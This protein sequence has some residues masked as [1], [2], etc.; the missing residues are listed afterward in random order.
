MSKLLRLIAGR[1]V[2]SSVGL[3][4]VAA[5]IWILGPQLAFGTA[6]PLESSTG[7]LI[8]IL[9]V[10]LI[11]VV[12]QLRKVLKANQANKG[13]VEGLVDAKTM[14]PDRSAEEVATL[15]DRFEKAVGVLRKSK[16]K[17]GS[18][19]LYDL[20]WYII[21]GPPGSGKTTALVNSGLEFPLA[22][23][24]GREALGGVG[25][26]RNCDW[27]FTDEAILLDT[28]GRYT[29]QDSDAKIDRSA[30]EGFLGLLRKYR[31]RR[32]INGVVVA[33][34]LLDLM[35]L[36]EHERVAHARAIKAR[37]QEL[38]QF[39]KI[40][41][42]V[43]V[44]LTKTDLVAGFAEFFEDLG[45]NE[46]EQV[47]GMTFPIDAS[48]SPTGAAER[49]LPEFDALLARLNARL[50]AR[51]S[52]E[53][54]P[55]RRAAI[56]G[57]PRQLASL[58]DNIGSFLG[59]VF[60]GS[61]FEQA[62]ML[63][64]VYFTSGTQEGTPI[65][66]LM[67]MV[68]RTFGLEQHMLPA[69][70][71]RGRSY[72]LKGLLKDVVFRESEVAGTNRKF[73]LQRVWLQRAAYVG[74]LSLAVLVSIGWGVSYLN[75]RAM[76]REVGTA[77]TAAAQALDQVQGAQDVLGL[78]PA[79][80][81]V[82]AIPAIYEGRDDA[83]WLQGLG[84]Y[85]GRKLSARSEAAYQRVLR[86]SLLPLLISRTEGHLRNGGAT[87][88]FQYEALK[89]YLMLDSRE[90]YDARAVIGWFEF[91]F[92]QFLSPRA[93]EPERTAFLAHL[94]ALF[95]EQPLPLPVALD[96]ALI[97][98][99]QRI[100]ARMA[101]E[102]RVYSRLRQS[103]AA[104]QLPDFT[105]FDAAGPRSQIVFTRRSGSGPGD[106]IDGFFTRDGYRQFFVSQSGAEASVL[107]DESWILGPYVPTNLD[108]DTVMARVKDLYLADYVQQYEALLADIALA[109]SSSAEETSDILNILS[110]P[111]NSPL[112]LLLRAVAEQTQLEPPAPTSQDAGA[113]A[114]ARGAVQRLEGLLGGGN[115]A[116][117]AAA[118]STTNLVDERF[119]WLRDL[120]GG[121]DAAAAPIQPVL[122]LI[123]ELY[124]FMA[125]VVAQRGLQGDIPT[126]LADQGRLVAQ[127]VR[128]EAGRQPPV[129]RALLQEAA[130]RSVTLATSGVRALLN[131]QWQSTALPFC[132]RAI[133]GR[134]PVA[135]ASAQ[136]I[137]LEDFGQFF[138]P[139][140]L[141]DTYFNEYLATYV[142]KSRSPWR[143]RPAAGAPT[144][145]AETLRQF[146]RAEAIK[147][148]FF[149]GGGALPAV[150]FELRPVEM[151]ETIIQ[152]T[153][154]LGTERLT[155]AHGPVLAK[156]L[157]WPGAAENSEVRIEMAPPV[158]GDSM[159]RQ[160]GP[161][162]WFRVLDRANV[163]AGDRPEVFEVEFRL[164]ERA[165]LYE[166]TARSAYNPFRFP[167]LEEFSCPESL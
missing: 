111:A 1:W 147:E 97:D 144:I 162:A 56:Y 23:H 59:D 16:G 35:T 137:R 77:T 71:G 79:L 72:F 129:I 69:Q 13:M 11:W 103:S 154:Q 45:R 135:R 60:R 123:D 75:N 5:S 57:F 99:T 43:Y 130:A 66:R 70:G 126:A 52:Q 167:E 113:A 121:A 100:V 20:P 14:D 134:Y 27:W 150:A 156:A 10:V 53:R 139:G 160:E 92:N 89:A 157:T 161:W 138:A 39:F 48:D 22:D 120:V 136:E 87:P 33:I 133:A 2:T 108:T 30:W 85:Q 62:P 109:P 164:G 4:A 86:E 84:L 107:I 88:D 131:T 94:N 25:G 46:R 32:P 153:L 146:E 140:G 151:S 55:R 76:A 158:Q 115:A 78:L 67:G 80:D 125:G 128:T 40:R 142:D 101:T 29:T 9:A 68:A 37:I 7:R 159:I 26:T 112:V 42:P 44:L 49:F 95:A 91:D 117:P 98:Q 6:R 64:G 74:S 124:K 19:S 104:D 163:A 122:G 47:W 8:A 152:F 81:A 119:R 148:T 114:A 132:R 36:N 90:H 106:G 82:K 116:Q 166:L 31:K 50:L 61:R 51:M 12:N 34:S 21:I 41:F 143:V 149:R 73:E 54:D 38:D 127:Q 110:D 118:A 24:F 145:T 96:T 102:N 83:P 15:K 155:Y 93:G 18:L 105:V 28:A 165:A 58:R 141:V 65:D 3:L 63:R 17:R